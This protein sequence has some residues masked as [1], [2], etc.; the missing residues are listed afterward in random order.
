M[1]TTGRRK[2]EGWVVETDEEEVMDRM[3]RELVG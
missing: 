1:I 2:V 3:A